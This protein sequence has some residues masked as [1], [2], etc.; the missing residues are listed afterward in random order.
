MQK[1]RCCHYCGQRLPESRFG[2]IFTPKEGLILDTLHRLG[3]LSNIELQD[4]TGMSRNSL[5]THINHINNKL[6]ETGFHVTGAALRMVKHGPP[7]FHKADALSPA[8]QK[9]LGL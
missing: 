9:A 1:N 6:A 4:I 2:I 3:R 5:C 8:R 7:R